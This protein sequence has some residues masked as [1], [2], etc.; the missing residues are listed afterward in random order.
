MSHSP[1]DFI[2]GRFFVAH[3]ATSQ[4]VYQQNLI[5]G[6]SRRDWALMIVGHAGNRVQA[7]WRVRQRVSAA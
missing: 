4:S 7:L 2:V 6:M 3:L 1:Y 5:A